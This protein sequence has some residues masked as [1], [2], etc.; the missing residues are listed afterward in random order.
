MPGPKYNCQEKIEVSAVA[1]V[2]LTFS[3]AKF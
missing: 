1:E 2:K 3:L